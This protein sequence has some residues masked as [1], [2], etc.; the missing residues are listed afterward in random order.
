MS[1]RRR[2]THAGAPVRLRLEP[3]ADARAVE[4]Q[5]AVAVAM[6][7]PVGALSA[8]SSRPGARA[9]LRPAREDVF[10]GRHQLPTAGGAS[11]GVRRRQRARAGP[12]CARHR[13]PLHALPGRAPR[14]ER[15]RRQAAQRSSGV[16]GAAAGVQQALVR[17]ALSQRAG[18]TAVRLHEL[19]TKKPSPRPRSTCTSPHS[20]SHGRLPTSDASA[21]LPAARAQRDS[22]SMLLSKC[23]WLPS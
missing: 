15:P 21:G 10:A 9:W 1:W 18:A 6:G 17:R 5:A 2:L 16:H 23:D 3:H 19:H 4:A 20:G 14:T 8:G 13:H 7:A 11:A 12:H 22:R